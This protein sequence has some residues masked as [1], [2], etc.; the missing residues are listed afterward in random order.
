MKNIKRRSFGLSRLFGSK[1]SKVCLNENRNP[2]GSFHVRDRDLASDSTGS[3]VT[4]SYVPNHPEPDPSTALKKPATQTAGGELLSS[5]EHL[6]PMMARLE[7][8]QIQ[9][10]LLG[11]DHP[12]VIFALRGIGKA[13]M[14]RGEFQEAQLVDEMIFAS[15]K[16][17][18]AAWNASHQHA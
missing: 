11:M 13:H 5:V 6:R 17:Q 10:E 4:Y 8:L 1:G 16:K 9:Q 18:R 12:D 2:F 14:R 15:Q 3:E 7:A